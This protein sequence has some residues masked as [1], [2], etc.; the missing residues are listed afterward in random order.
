MGIRVFG[1]WSILLIPS[2]IGTSSSS[3]IWDFDFFC[4]LE[5]GLDLDFD[6]TIDQTATLFFAYLSRVE[7]CRV[8]NYAL[9]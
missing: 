1:Y 5:L 9:L 2:L 4:F 7:R 8:F 3:C 6:P